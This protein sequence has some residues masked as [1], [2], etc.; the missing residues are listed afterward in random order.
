M[1]S[2]SITIL[3]KAMLKKFNANYFYRPKELLSFTQIIM[4]SS[5]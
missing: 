4:D 1:Q 5:S 2:P 3:M